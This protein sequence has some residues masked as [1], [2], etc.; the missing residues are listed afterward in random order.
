MTNTTTTS[1][2]SR[3]TSDLDALKKATDSLPVA[4]RQKILDLIYKVENRNARNSRI[5]SIAQSAICDLRLQFKYLQFDLDA[6][7]RERD[8]FAS[9]L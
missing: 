2:A 9:L 4:S 7:R 8:H 3:V 5:L 6:T 1:L